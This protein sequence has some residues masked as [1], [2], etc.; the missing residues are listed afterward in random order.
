MADQSSSIG[1]VDHTQSE[2]RVTPSMRQNLK[3]AVKRLE[4]KYGMKFKFIREWPKSKYK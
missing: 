1:K 4:S 2:I 3:D